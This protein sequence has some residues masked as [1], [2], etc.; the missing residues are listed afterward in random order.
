MRH[1][2]AFWKVG[3]ALVVVL[4][5]VPAWLASTASNTV[6]TTRLALI[7]VP[8]GV[9]DLKPGECSAQTLTTLLIA[10][11]NG[12]TNGGASSELIL[13]GPGKQTINGKGGDDCIVAGGEKDDVDGGTGTDVCIISQTSSVTHCETV[14]RR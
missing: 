2:F 14:V 12:T 4:A 8:I 3:L 5:V 13:G 10:A 11:P 1:S 6:P 7:A 9:N